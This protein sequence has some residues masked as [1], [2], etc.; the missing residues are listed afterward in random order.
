M[1]GKIESKTWNP[2]T[3]Q[4]YYQIKL[5]KQWKENINERVLG[6]FY[7]NLIKEYEIK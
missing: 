2:T 4:L 6:K 7:V 3:Q 5:S 1:S